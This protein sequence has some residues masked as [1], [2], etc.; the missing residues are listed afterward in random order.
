MQFDANMMK[1]LLKKS[2]AELWQT[3]RRVAEANGIT[4]P[5]GTPSAGDMARLRAIL[6]TKGPGD[7]AEAMEVLRRARGGQ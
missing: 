1:E 7:V 3:V 6:G 5:E 4:L 2:D